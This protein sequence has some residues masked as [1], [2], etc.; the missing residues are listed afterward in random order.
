[1][2]RYGRWLLVALLALGGLILLQVVLD[3]WPI[4]QK[5][6]AVALVGAFFAMV[7]AAV[8]AASGW[9]ERTRPPRVLSVFGFSRIPLGLFLIL[10]LA[11]ADL[12]PGGRHYH[13][14]RL[15]APPSLERSIFMTPDEAYLRWSSEQDLGGRRDGVR[16]AVPMV[17][18]A[19]AGGGIK[20]AVWTSLVLDCVFHGGPGVNAPASRDACALANPRSRNR[21]GSA[22]VASGISGGSLGLV[23]YLTHERETGGEID[24][25]WIRRVLSDDFVSPNLAWQLFVEAPRALLR[26]DIG[27]DRGEV[28]E[29]S[30]ERAW[31]TDDL[32]SSAG[33]FQ[34]PLHEDFLAFQHAY[35]ELPV[36]MLNG[37]TVEGGCR[38]VT[39]LIETTGGRSRREC[40]A[41]RDFQDQVPPPLGPA[42]VV[43]QGTISAASL[44][45]ADLLCPGEDG[46]R[47]DVASS[48]AALLSARFPFV[49][50]T[51]RIQFCGDPTASVHVVDGGYLDGSGAGSI[52]DVWDA[53]A[54]NLDEWN[55]AG[56]D[57]CI[58]PY[59]IQID[60]GYESAAVDT[61]A[62]SEPLA[63]LRGNNAARDSRSIE[64]RNAAALAF[65]RPLDGVRPIDR[66]AILNLRAHPG[67]QAPLGWTLSP[68]S[69][70]ELDQQLSLNADQLRE[71]G[72]WF[73]GTGCA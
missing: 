68:Q 48:T 16:R 57:T 69:V 26:Y 22:F 28:L 64:G 73:Q 3:V 27:M 67:S 32:A 15:S 20:A 49:S 72:T 71:I 18:V 29:R 30:W 14:V 52:T 25:G 6:G 42:R 55:G 24:P 8:G 65:H 38:F 66:Y 34:G 31:A 7:A 53:V 58:V 19:T 13:D 1:M 41:L 17:F 12:V 62:V 40:S 21:I 39:S 46:L 11:L 50:P 23:E 61:D 59:L 60:S 2:L 45:L 9:I 5:M 4:S 63:P 33:D 35:R 56:H 36:L 44:D 10:W 37:A 43:E 47:S 70:Q 51:G 54:D